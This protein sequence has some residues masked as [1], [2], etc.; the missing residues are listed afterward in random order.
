LLLEKTEG[1]LP[2]RREA[3]R[4][5]SQS[6]AQPSAAV[7]YILKVSPKNNGSEQIGIDCRGASPGATISKHKHLGRDE[8]LFIETGTVHL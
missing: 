2:L 5:S 8:I 7:P 1:E 6:D 4:A 3:L